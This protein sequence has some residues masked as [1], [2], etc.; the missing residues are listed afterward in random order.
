M[1]AIPA[2]IVHLQRSYPV[3]QVFALV[4]LYLYGAATI[5]GFAET[6][7]IKSMLVLAAL[8]GLAAAGQTL[9]VILGGLDFSIPGFIVM[10]AILVSELCGKHGWGL[11][12]ALVLILVLAIVLGGLE[13]WLCHRYRINPL[14]LTLGF[15]S[16]AVGGVLAW[17]Q[18]RLT[19]AAPEEIG[20]LVR[21]NSSTFGFDV[22]PIVVIWAVFAIVMA[23][24]LHRTRNGRGLFLTGANV[25]AADL[26]HIQTRK[27]W[28]VAFAFSAA[29]A[30][31]VG[32]LL[33]GFS[34]AGQGIGDTYLFQGLT[35]VIVGGTTFMGARGDYS[36]TVVGALLLTV[37]TTIFVGRDLD[38][39]DQQIIFG[40]LILIVVAGYGR[41]RALSS[42]V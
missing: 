42:R 8:L 21:V 5:T 1:S 14:V 37:L 35:A 2:R 3:A 33:A 7:S 4:V 39:A 40:I 25:R 13:G 30:A 38:S 17:T 22:P 12:P 26:A 19:G 29:M 20:T 18:S 36:H 10:G 41:E 32:V 34:G 31:L 6:S 27:V 28:T 9:V 23:I 16:I 11:L 24:F 15:G